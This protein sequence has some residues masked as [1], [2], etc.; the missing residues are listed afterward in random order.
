MA[1]EQRLRP[2]SRRSLGRSQ[3]SVWVKGPK[4]VYAPGQRADYILPR[5]F[6]SRRDTIPEEDEDGCKCLDTF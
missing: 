5:A 4:E 6:A 1:L 3:R 2:G